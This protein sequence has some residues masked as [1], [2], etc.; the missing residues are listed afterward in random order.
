MPDLIC[1][2]RIAAGVH[3]EHIK[4]QLSIAYVLRT[5]VQGEFMLISPA[6]YANELS[7]RGFF[8]EYAVIPAKAG[9]AVKRQRYP[10]N[11]SQMYWMFA[12]AGIMQ[13]TPQPPN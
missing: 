4:I 8:M 12:C 1:L 6:K 10:E 9:H 2:P 7:S 11:S 5:A 13:K 3:S